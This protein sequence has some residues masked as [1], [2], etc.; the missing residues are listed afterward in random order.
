MKQILK[1]KPEFLQKTFS[2]SGQKKPL[3]ILSMNHCELLSLIQETT[4]RNPWIVLPEESFAFVSDQTQ[5]KPDLYTHLM[6][7]VQMTPEANEEVLMYLIGQLDSNGYFRVPFEKLNLYPPSLVQKQIEIGSQLDPI[8]CFSFHLNDCLSAQCKAS[9]DPVSQDALKLLDHLELVASRSWGK[10]SKLTGL[11]TEQIESAFS[12]I[13]TLF[14]K[15]AA[16]FDTGAQI[17]NCDAQIT[18][19]EGNLHVSLP[20]DLDFTVESESALGGQSA[21]QEL[22]ALRKEAVELLNCLQR[23]N[24]TFLQIMEVLVRLQKEWF[25]GGDKSYLT[26]QMVADECGLHPSTV[27]RAVNGKGFLYENRLWPVRCLFRHDGKGGLSAQALSQLI[28]DLIKTEDPAE[29]YSDEALCYLLRRHEIQLSRRTVAKYRRTANIPD[30][31]AR[32][33]K[34]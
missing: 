13:Q 9:S 22:K 12:F 26:L 16:N 3:E 23:R 17:L 1:V 6:E 27:C 28:T 11:N 20:S 33:K 2:Y 8:G 19:T 7:Q 32:K 25:F 29:P 5:N 4:H 15:P 24:L 34:S 30:S 14:P 10:L 21:S 18:L 31:F